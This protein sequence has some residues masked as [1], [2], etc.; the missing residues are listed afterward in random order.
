MNVELRDID[1]IKP[2]DRDPRKNDAALEHVARS[3]RLYGFRQPIVVD[4]DGVI[5]VGHTRL[6]TG[7]AAA[8]RSSTASRRR[9]W[10]GSAGERRHRRLR[11]YGGG[12]AE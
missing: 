11:V 8:A 4:K 5:V 9:Q 10:R 2:Y 6:E 1:S 7:A 12:V 3:I